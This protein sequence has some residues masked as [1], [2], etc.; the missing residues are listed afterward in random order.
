MYILY[1]FSMFHHWETTDTSFVFLFIIE[2]CIKCECVSNH[3]MNVVNIVVDF[4][5]LIF[6]FYIFYSYIPYSHRVSRL[7]NIS[8]R[9]NCL[10]QYNWVSWGVNSMRKVYFAITVIIYFIIIILFFD[11]VV[12]VSS[13]VFVLH[14][15][16]IS[17][18]IYIFCCSVL[19]SKFLVFNFRLLLSKHCAN[20][21]SH[22][23]LM[24]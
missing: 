1:T 23:T 13:I 7:P 24:K 11:S 3:R 5:L 4:V 21:V 16:L 19:F 22:Q 15:T 2:C 6:F 8:F 17:L 18:S 9:W 12:F 10:R 14:L 20:P